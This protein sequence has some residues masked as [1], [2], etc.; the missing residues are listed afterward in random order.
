MSATS[1][2]FDIQNNREVNGAR[3][4]D[5]LYIFTG[6][7]PVYYKGDG[8]LYMFPEYQ[9][10]FSEQV[11]AGPNTMMDDFEDYYYG[12]NFKDLPFNKSADS[13]S[14]TDFDFQPKIPYQIKEDGDTL[15]QLE[16]RLSYDY[17]TL[18]KT[19]FKGFLPEGAQGV[20]YNY[21]GAV[22]ALTDIPGPNF[23]KEVYY[24]RNFKRFVYFDSSAAGTLAD[25]TWKRVLLTS[26]NGFDRYYEIKANVYFRDSAPGTSEEDWIL[27]DEEN[28]QSDIRSNSNLSSRFDLVDGNF[29]QVEDRTGSID[30][31][32]YFSVK[33]EGLTAGIKDIKVEFVVNRF[34]YESVYQDTFG[35]IAA[36]FHQYVER[37]IYKESVEFDEV[38]ITAARLQNYPVDEEGLRNRGGFSLHAPWSANKVIEHYGKLLAFGSLEDPETVFIGIKDNLFYF[39]Y[40][41]TIGFNTDLKEP[42]NSITPFMNILVVQSDSYTWGLKGQSPQ[43]YIDELGEELNPLAYEAIT[44]NSSVGS[45]AP[46]AVRPV[47]NRLYFLSQEGLMELTSL[48][49]TDDR[50][51]VKPLDRNIKNLIPQDKNAVAIQFDNQYWIHFPSTGETFRYYIDKE[52]WVKDSYDFNTFNGIY[53]YYIKDGKLHFVTNPLTITDGNA[54]IYEGVIEDKLVSDFGVPI[55]TS[56]LT[57]KMH[58]EYP[59]HWKRYKEYKLDFSVQNEYIPDLDSVE[60]LSTD[61]D[62]PYTITANF[63]PNHQYALSLNI[64]PTYDENEEEY[65]YPVIQDLTVQGAINP[66][67]VDSVIYFTIGNVVPEEVTVNFSG[68]TIEM[69]DGIVLTD[70][71][72]DKNLAF[73][74]NI[75]SDNNSLIR[76]VDVSNS[77]YDN[78]LALISDEL[79]VMANTFENIFENSQFGKAYKFLHTSKLYGSGYDIEMYYEDS[80]KVKWTLETIGVTYKMR[81]TRS[82]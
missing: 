16:I 58:Q 26:D 62:V 4:K 57:S 27:I 80:S 77:Y 7:Y 46:K 39:P 44:I 17:R 65:I 19:A 55:K 37:T 15:P 23:E 3:I 30:D 82:R 25:P 36:T 69:F 14:I 34:S 61:T 2:L 70:E 71:T 74:I 47:R 24:I 28:V 63:E 33:V 48:F 1:Y 9:P 43:I 6:S 68:A 11:V 13:N 67:S 54:T 64:T 5:V 45:I 66:T 20:D 81:R 60:I 56:F 50:Y 29:D 79:G 12:R 8:K 53:R 40:N 49:A 32:S 31:P 72:Y 35:E 78:E 38:E 52:A 41:Y 51:N 22:D 10:S 18:Y 73:N 75:V 76:G 42:V 21:S 59:F